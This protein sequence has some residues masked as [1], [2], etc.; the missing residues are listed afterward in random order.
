MQFEN[1]REGGADHVEVGE[2]AKGGPE[3]RASLDTLDPQSIRQ[4]HAEYGYPLVVIGTSHRPA[5]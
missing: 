1:V 5:G 4:Q 3:E 2:G